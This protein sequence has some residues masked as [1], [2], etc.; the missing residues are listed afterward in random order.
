MSRPAFTLQNVDLQNQHGNLHPQNTN[1]YESMLQ[2]N[3]LGIYD[4]GKYHNSSDF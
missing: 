4:V 2:Q 1:D 3:P